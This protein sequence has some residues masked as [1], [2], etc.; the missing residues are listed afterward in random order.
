MSTEWRYRYKGGTNAIGSS[1][2]SWLPFVSEYAQ[3]SFSVYV[4]Y[5]GFVKERD[6]ILKQKLEVKE[7]SE[8]G[9]DA[10]NQDDGNTDKTD[11]A[12]AKFS[13]PPPDTFLYEQQK[14]PEEHERKPSPEE[15]KLKQIEEIMEID[16]E[17]NILSLKD[18]AIVWNRGSQFGFPRLRIN[19]NRTTTV[20]EQEI[21]SFVT[22]QIGCFV[23]IGK[24]WAHCFRWRFKGWEP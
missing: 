16:F 8:S 23:W 7:Q 5:S 15:L 24:R 9:G 20:T 18:L 17:R 21:R 19:Q 22:E 11:N 10:N 14:N 13:Q 2:I 12:D 1:I 3:A 4:L 6:E